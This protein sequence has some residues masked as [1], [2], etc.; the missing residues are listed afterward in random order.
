ML[1]RILPF[2]I[3]KSRAILPTMKTALT[4]SQAS[5]VNLNYFYDLLF[6]HKKTG[7][8]ASGGNLKLVHVVCHIK[9]PHEDKCDPKKIYLCTEKNARSD[10]VDGSHF[11]ETSLHRR[12]SRQKS[13]RANLEHRPVKKAR[14]TRLST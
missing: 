7:C 8:K 10:A 14:L 3:E 13:K 9:K 6:C 5:A 4:G 1:I 12:T 11:K 2:R